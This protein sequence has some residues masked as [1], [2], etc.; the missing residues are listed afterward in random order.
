[1]KK[2]KLSDMVLPSGKRIGD[3]TPKEAREGSRILARRGVTFG[4]Y[5]KEAQTEGTVKTTVR[6]PKS[7]W[8]AARKRAIDQDMDFQGIV[9]IALAECLHLPDGIEELTDK[10]IKTFEANAIKREESR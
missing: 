3:V 10:Q 2:E 7:L 5:A 1:M 4:Y 9:L 8:Q 6:L